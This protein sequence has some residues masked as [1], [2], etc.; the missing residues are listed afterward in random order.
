MLQRKNLQDRRTLR[1]TALQKQARHRII[2]QKRGIRDTMLKIQFDLFLQ[3]H[4]PSRDVNFRVRP[5]RD[6]RPTK[7]DVLITP[8][9]YFI[10]FEVLATW[11]DE[12]ER[13]F[14]EQPLYWLLIGPDSPLMKPYISQI[15]AG[16][17][18]NYNEIRSLQLFKYLLQQLNASELETVLYAQM[19]GSS[20]NASDTMFASINGWSADICKFLP[21]PHF[22]Q[23]N[24]VQ[25]LYGHVLLICIDVQMSWW[26]QPSFGGDTI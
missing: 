11:L 1:F 9:I 19:F 10:G 6:M 15:I 7:A 5:F 13:D 12:E 8:M 18:I 17:S 2:R 26:G 16:K 3:G 20:Y 4:I 14:A 25:Q 22:N 24:P 23:R 21:H